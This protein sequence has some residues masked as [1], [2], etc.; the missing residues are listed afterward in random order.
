MMNETRPGLQA[1]SQNTNRIT[2][3]RRWWA[4]GAVLLTIFFGSLDQTVV[5]TAMPV[6]VGDLE[7]F[8][9]Y[10]WVFTAYVIASAVTVPIYGKLSDVYGRKPFYIFGLSIFIAGSA[11]SGQSHS[12][13]ELILFRGL[14]GIG[15]GAMLSMP[16]ATIG[17]IF[18]PRE[19]GR[20]MGVISTTFGLASIV[21]PFLGGWITDNLGWPWIFYINLPIAALALAGILYALP[22][23][24]IEQDVRVDWAGS[25]L[26]VVGLI[27]LLLAFTW[28]GTQYPWGSP[29][30]LGLFAFAVTALALFT[31]VERRAVEPVIPLKLFKVPIFG[32]ATLVGFLLSVGMFGTL[33][34]MPLYVQGVL[35]LSAQ[36]SGVIT[37]PLMFSFVAS[38]LVAGQIMTRTGKYKITAVVA[39]ALMAV[40]LY[41]FTR[42]GVNTPYTVVVWDMV[43]M[44]F[45]LGGML[46]IMNVAVQ[47]AFPYHM[48][49]IVNAAQQF[50]RSLGAVIAAPIL[51][52]VLANVFA[53]QM[54]VNEPTA[55]AEA[56]ARLPAAD[57]QALT[58]PQSL[59][60]AQA[61]AAIQ[62]K[63]A[64][65]GAQGQELY[66]Q[67]IT[68]VHKSLTSGMDRLFLIAFLFGL[69]TLAATL[70]LPEIQ[71]KLDEFYEEAEKRDE[72]P[73]ED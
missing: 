26:L 14:Q 54:K 71:L 38:A 65:F 57:Q 42:L 9:I 5:G 7:G 46:P 47:N 69:A 72:V 58:D 3:R 35:N 53:A 22:S 68:A 40:G 12:M 1:K 25:S 19:R 56:L 64:S 21:G 44:G 52:T 28:A 30:I 20:W 16:R 4:L 45:G 49:G 63:F 66:M 27:P 61:Q 18:N 60:N 39:A 23:V 34:F 59:T 6:I 29:V 55:L 32:V 48:M 50:V 8:D 70:F 2:D 17:D 67:F 24:R 51:G 37:T 31:W 15:A 36:N 62:A 33:L 10:A 41:L 73:R 13:I 43:I 11:L